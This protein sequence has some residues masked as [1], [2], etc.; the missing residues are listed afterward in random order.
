V[1]WLYEVR[2]SEVYWSV[3][4]TPISKDLWEW[5]RKPVSSRFSS[6]IGNGIDSALFHSVGK[7]VFF[8]THCTFLT[9]ILDGVY[10]YLF[11]SR[12]VSLA[13]CLLHQVPGEVKNLPLGRLTFLG[14]G[15]ATS[16]AKG[17]NGVAFLTE[18]CA[19]WLMSYS[20]VDICERFWWKS[21]CHVYGEDGHGRFLRNRRSQPHILEDKGRQMSYWLLSVTR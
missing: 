17:P 16:S 6:Q 3:T 4:R 15:Y 1:H 8:V 11:K 14:Q 19:I 2:R 9:C 7:K 21:C 20:L 10:F 13:G 18:C 12:S 5:C